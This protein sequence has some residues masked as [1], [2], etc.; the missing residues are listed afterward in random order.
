MRMFVETVFFK[1]RYPK[2][3]SKHYNTPTT[4]K[5]QLLK[6]INAN[7]TRLHSYLARETINIF[8]KNQI[9]LYYI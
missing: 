2:S 8:F 9:R 3:K 4:M 1:T 6:D 5:F 7:P